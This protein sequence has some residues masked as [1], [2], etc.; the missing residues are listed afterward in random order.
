M[1]TRIRKE[2]DTGIWQVVDG[3]LMVP[4][5]NWEEAIHFVHDMGQ[6]RAKSQKPTKIQIVAEEYQ[7]LKT[8]LG[9]KL[10]IQRLATVYNVT[11]KTIEKYLTT[12]NSPRHDST[13]A[14]GG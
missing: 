1:K 8:I 13:T 9:C 6:H 2:P 12:W 14:V 4:A 3:R 7:H 11:P 5:A 10:A